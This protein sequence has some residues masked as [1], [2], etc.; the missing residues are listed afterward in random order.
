MNTREWGD[1]IVR[2]RRRIGWL[3]KIGIA[4]I[5]TALLAAVSGASY[6]A[7]NWQGTADIAR[8]IAIGETDEQRRIEAMVGA[9][10]D[11]K[12]TIDVLQEV[13]DGEGRAAARA[14]DLL[15]HLREKAER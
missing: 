13:A 9:Y 2:T 15:R 14:R 10:R 8:A 3:R 11:A 1:S 12:A 5:A 6:R 4:L 7:G